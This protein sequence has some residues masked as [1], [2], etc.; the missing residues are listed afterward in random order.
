MNLEEQF[1][2]AEADVANL[3]FRPDND[4]LLRLYGFHKQVMKGDA[5]DEDPSGMFD[6]VGKA[7]YEAWNKQKGRTKEQCMTDYI[8]L[9]EELKA[10]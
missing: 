1:K 4:T 10:R 8:A 9:V 7:K 3:S 6:F 2:K 5:P